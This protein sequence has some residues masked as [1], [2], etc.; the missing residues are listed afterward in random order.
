MN[1]LL[2]QNRS[3]VLDPFVAE[4]LISYTCN[5]AIKK[6]DKLNSVLTVARHLFSRRVDKKMTLYKFMGIF[7]H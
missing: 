4:E 1:G 2:Q 3:D 7:A 5:K 6:E